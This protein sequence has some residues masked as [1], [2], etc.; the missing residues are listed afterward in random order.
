MCGMKNKPLK[1]RKVAIYLL[2]RFT[3]LTNPEIGKKFAITFSAVSKA[4]KYVEV[5][6]GKDKMVR[7]KVETII[8][9]FKGRPVIGESMGVEANYRVK[10][11]TMSMNRYPGHGYKFVMLH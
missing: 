4:A 10:A 8:S 2:K 11:A 5:L 6:M 7:R 9:S 3:G 1:E